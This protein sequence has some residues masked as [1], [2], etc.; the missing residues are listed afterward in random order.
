MNYINIIKKKEIKTEQ[1][2]VEVPAQIKMLCSIFKGTIVG[3][4]Q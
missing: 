3:G 4:K 2:N 1:S